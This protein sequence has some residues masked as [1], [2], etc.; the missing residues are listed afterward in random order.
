M[1]LTE[2]KRKEEKDQAPTS[3]FG[4]FLGKLGG[5]GKGYIPVENPTQVD[6]LDQTF[7]VF[8]GGVFDEKYT[9]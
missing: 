2:L 1:V 8:E 5:K 3:I 7:K 9:V 6:N 4:S